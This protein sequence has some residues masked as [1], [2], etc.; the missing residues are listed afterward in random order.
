MRLAAPSASANR[1]FVIVA[2][3]WLIA[4]LA[5]LVTVFSVYLSNSARALALADEAVQAQGLV[6]AG[7]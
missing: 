1:G 2:V 3:L 5:A 7:V 4:A 6:S